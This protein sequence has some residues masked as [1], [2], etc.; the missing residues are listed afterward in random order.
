MKFQSCL[1]H[2]ESGDGNLA[3]HRWN[4]EHFLLEQLSKAFANQHRPKIS[5]TAGS[6]PSHCMVELMNERGR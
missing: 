6:T 5:T 4:T 2:F 1:L 3:V